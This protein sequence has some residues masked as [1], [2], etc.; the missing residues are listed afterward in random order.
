MDDEVRPQDGTQDR[1][2]LALDLNFVPTWAR[3][4]PENPYAGREDA[5]ARERGR[6]RRDDRRGPFGRRDGGD[7]RAP[8]PGGGP[9]P[10]GGFRPG[11]DRRPEGRF[12]PAG[13]GPPGGGFRPREGARPE[14]GF[15]RP[16]REGDR[17]GPRRDGERRPPRETLPRLDVRVAFLPDRE[18][19]ALVVRDIQV[20]R[21]AFP[22]IEI[23]SRF[24][25]REDLYLVKLELPAAPE[26]AG[27]PVLV[28]CL[29]C[30]RVF[31]SRANAEAHILN[32][33][34]DK[35]FTVEETEVEPPAGVF[36]C[37]ARCGL[38]GTLLGPPNY[39]GY[40][41]KIQEL[42]SA[43]FAHLSKAEYLGHIETVRD[44]ARVEQW[45]DSLRKKTVYRLKEVPEGQEVAAM[46]R[47]E[48][49]DWMRAGKVHPLLRESARCMVPG[50]QSRKFDDP[51]LR[52]AVSL[53]WQKESRF[54]FT[55]S[56]ALRPA[57]RHMHLH[58]FKVN[59][60][61]TYVT[62]VAPVP[63]D[64]ET[65]PGIVK[66]IAAFL[67]AHPG[68]SRQQVLE[69]LRMGADPESSEAAELLLHLGNLIA[70]GGVI[71][72]FNGTLVLPRRN[73]KPEAPP[74]AAGRPPAG[75]ETPAE[76]AASADEIE[77]EEE[78]LAAEPVAEE[79]AVAP[80]A[81]TESPPEG[82]AGVP[83]AAP[84]PDLSM[85]TAAPVAA[86]AAPVVAEKQNPQEPV[87][88]E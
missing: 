10:E 4:P 35:F 17:H 7:R 67:E 26:G 44:E 43:R 74:A 38:S 20:S 76:T 13:G 51:A 70:N 80:E 36:A 68:S 84:E 63:V 32:D 33:H 64:P 52:S 45:K 1:S 24:L 57:F 55:L 58:L 15:S 88:P 30:K 25:G 37:V 5:G 83:V 39:H 2:E 28:Q 53:A 6:E 3:Q 34:L 49:Q 77:S 86:A 12:R 19:L 56:L 21:R 78:G 27:R 66:E 41:E 18:R 31:R 50:P 59:A 42:W 47:A 40:N 87:Q 54:P 85:S 14:G 79:P 9:R 75:P 69:G 46:S 81:V 16:P 65:A 22:L 71:E 82:F 8:R 60:R 72:F 29:E 73:P 23:A 48:A 61:E 62:A 11:G